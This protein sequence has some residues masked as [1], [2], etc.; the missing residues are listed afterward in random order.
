M[1]AVI[2]RHNEKGI[3]GFAATLRKANVEYDIVNAYLDEIPQDFD[4][5]ASELLIVMGGSPGVYQ[6]E[7]YSFLKQELKILEKRLAA[8][9]PT[10]GVC[11][12]CQLMAGALGGKNFYGRERGLERELGWCEVT[13]NDAGAKTPVRHFDKKLTRVVQSHVDSFDLPKGAALLASSDI[14]ENQAFAWGQNA[15]GV[16][17]HPEADLQAC[18]SWYVSNSG[19]VYRGEIDLPEWKKNTDKYLPAMTQQS[20]RFLSEWLAQMQKSAEKRCA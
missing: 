19:A 12:G 3:G 20:D 6:S 10:L 1:K 13:V 9:L 5:L 18:K 17:F 14:Y 11:L 16:Q 7:T 4:P 15:L 2:L 8:D